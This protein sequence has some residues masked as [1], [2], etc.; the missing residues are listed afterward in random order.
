MGNARR[1][2]RPQVTGV[3]MTLKDD[4]RPAAGSGPQAIGLPSSVGLV[5]AVLAFAFV[6]SSTFVAILPAFRF[7]SQFPAMLPFFLWV[8]AAGLGHLARFGRLLLDRWRASFGLVSLVPYALVL[9]TTSVAPQVE[10]PWWVAPVAAL[11]AAV[12]FVLAAL[13]D[14][15]GAELVAERRVTNESLRG[16]FLIGCATMGVV[17]SIGGPPIVGTIVGVLLA[18]ALGVGGLLP[19]GVASATRAW[20]LR[21]WAALTWGSAIAWVAVPLSATTQFFTDAWYL[22]STMVI[23]GLPL[24]LVNRADA[25]TPRG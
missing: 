19:H 15:S 10:V 6:L 13:R 8:A 14:G 7:E 4:A 22:A 1:I 23:A 24:I 12:P 18:L 2:V 9:I 20:G 3:Q 16:T 25:Q 5:G 21:H 17:W 11:F